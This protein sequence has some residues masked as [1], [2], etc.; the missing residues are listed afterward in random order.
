MDIIS[1]VVVPGALTG[2]V[3][4]VATT[5][6]G[7]MHFASSVNNH[8]IHMDKLKVQS[9]DDRGPRPKQLLLSAAAGCVGMELIAILDKMRIGIDA[10]DINISAS[11][12]ESIPK[13]YKEVHLDFLVKCSVEDRAKFEKAIAL[14]L[15]KYCGVI[16]MF[17]NFAS[18]TH[19]IQY[20][21]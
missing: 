6:M 14:T 11:L 15:E 1:T 10:L 8:T 12:S 7:K 21:N 9:G 19:N 20:V 18:V 5:W 3:H 4:R 2:D 13:I 17:R 16:A